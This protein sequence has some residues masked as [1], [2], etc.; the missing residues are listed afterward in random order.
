MDDKELFLNWVNTKK[1]IL[2]DIPK[3]TDREF[4]PSS[5]N[6][7]EKIDD[8]ID[9]HGWTLEMSINQLDL[10]LKRSYEMGLKT[11]KIIHGKGI[12]SESEPVLKIGIRK[13]LDTYGSRYITRWVVSNKNDG[14][15]GAVV[16]YLKNNKRKII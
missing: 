5:K 15:D 13:W 7:I 3:T 12:N 1:P 11:L 8:E 4:L 9:F 6:T 2:K 16:V 14:G 10:F